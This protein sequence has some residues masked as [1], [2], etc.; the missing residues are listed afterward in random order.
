MM[1]KYKYMVGMVAAI[2]TMS[3]QAVTIPFDEVVWT[4]KEKPDYCFIGSNHAGK[5]FALSFEQQAGK[6][7]T[8]VL[9]G[10]NIT[11]LGLQTN[12]SVNHPVWF[13]QASVVSQQVLTDLPTNNDNGRLVTSLHS[14]DLYQAFKSGWWMTYQGNNQEVVFPSTGINKKTIE[15]DKCIANLP[16]IGFDDAHLT[17]ITFVNG[18]INLSSNQK[19]LVSNISDLIKKDNDISKVYIDGYTDNIGGDITNLKLS[20]KRASEVAYAMVLNGVKKDMIRV[21]GQ[22]SRNP[23]YSNATKNG[24]ERNRRVEIR[25]IKISNK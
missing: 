24:R 11:R 14:H 4:V 19:I 25:L 6:S 8:M 7:L 15:F 2:L 18:Q 1:M 16:N 20:K 12:V 21:T 13:H 3:V 22:G 10:R 17:N 5:G 23:I 9:T